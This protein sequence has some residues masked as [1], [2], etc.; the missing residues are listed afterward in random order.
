VATPSAVYLDRP[1]VATVAAETP[2]RELGF[3]SALAL[4]MGSMVGSGVFLLPASLAAYRGLSLVGWLISAGGSVALALVFARLA[5]QFP[6]H[7]GVYAYSRRAF[8]DAVGFLV[9][10]GYWLS[11]VAALAALAVAFVGYLDPFLPGLVRTPLWAGALAV[12]VI[13]SLVTVNVRG[14]GLAGQV[15]VA[16]TA[17]KLVP[18]LVVGVGG[19]LWLDASAFVLPDTSVVPAGSQVIAVV[20]L[21][22]F[23]F[24]GMESATIPAGRVTDP[25]RTIPRATVW[26]TLVTAGVYIVC[27]IGVMSLVPPDALAVSTAPFADGA[28]RMF[29]E[30][31]ARVVGLGAA[32]SCLGAL[33]GWVLAAGQLPVAVA[34]DGLLPPALG[35]LNRRGTPGPALIVAGVLASAL[36][37]MNYSRG[38]VGMYTFVVLLSTMTSVVAYVF[39]ALAVWLMPGHPAPAGVAAVISGVAF[40]YALAAVAGAGTETVY[41]GF[42]MLLAGLPLLVAVRRR[43]PGAALGDIARDRVPT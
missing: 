2:P 34:G 17:V 29:G 35:R 38:L 30:T 9:A 42:L 5:R 31:G 12:V 4:V 25:A 40:V 39:C 16:T 15:Q 36:V 21:T 13:W 14:V 1:S 23:A 20:T 26:G 33:N 41:Y 8:G 19:L 22:L 3:W 6:A 10:W 43:T 7:G 28:R 18:L 27:T 11:I 24:Q 32:L 37:V